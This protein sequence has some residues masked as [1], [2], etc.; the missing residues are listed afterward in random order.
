M[1]C[2]GTDS[3]GLAPGTAFGLSLHQEL[4]LFVDQCGFTPIEA[5]RTTTSV[6]AR[7]FNFSD[8]GRIQEGMRA[9]LVLVEG[10]PTTDIRHTLDLRG[11]WIAGELCSYYKDQLLD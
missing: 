10:D 4:E 2:S 3:A 6:T 8:R 5:L 1:I 7:R 11:V 9:D